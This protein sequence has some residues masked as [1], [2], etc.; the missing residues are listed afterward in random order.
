LISICTAG[1]MGV[2]AIVEG[3]AAQARPERIEHVPEA[4]DAL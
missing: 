3:V 2:A 1:G 4:A